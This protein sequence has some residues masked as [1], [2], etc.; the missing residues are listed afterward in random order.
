MTPVTANEAAGGRG[1]RGPQPAG[2][3]RGWREPRVGRP[4]L[5]APSSGRCA[6]DSGGSGID[7]ASAL[8]GE[9][10]DPDG[11]CAVPERW[12]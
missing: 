3:A 9:G 11:A 7:S 2:G 10:Q 4:E 8:R 1:A 6:H 12:F 5:G